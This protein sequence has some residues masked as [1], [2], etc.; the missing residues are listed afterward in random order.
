MAQQEEGT[1]TEGHRGKG[2]RAKHS[3]TGVSKKGQPGIRVSAGVIQDTG[4]EHPAKHRDRAQEGLAGM[5]DGGSRHCGGQARGGGAGMGGR[6][7]GWGRSRHG[8]AGTGVRGSTGTGEGRG[9][10]PGGWGG[11][12]RG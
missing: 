1:P 8:G 9:S 4:W 5:G 10:R 12:H 2:V 11:R 6:D 7:G 3:A